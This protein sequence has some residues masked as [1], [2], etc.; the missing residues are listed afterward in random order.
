MTGPSGPPPPLD[1]RQKN[2]GKAIQSLQ[3]KEGLQD[4]K[5][6]HAWASFREYHQ[7]RPDI[8]DL[9]EHFTMDVIAAGHDHYG[10]HGIIHRIRWHT[11]IEKKGKAFKISNTAFP[12]YARLF[13][14][15]H[16]RHS[17]FFRTQDKPLTGLKGM[18]NDPTD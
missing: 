14:A 10:A 16:P 3:T 9:F 11:D 12:F 4:M 15:L 6:Y 1:E 13:M 8:Y 17:K 5:A 2:I 18:S 7:H